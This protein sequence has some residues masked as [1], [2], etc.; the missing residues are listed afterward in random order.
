LPARKRSAGRCGWFAHEGILETKVG[1]GAGGMDIA[2]PIWVIGAGRG[3]ASALT[4]R[5]QAHH[6]RLEGGNREARL[7][8]AG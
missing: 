5:L 4:G 7:H 8:D 2:V 3:I 1:S 6:L